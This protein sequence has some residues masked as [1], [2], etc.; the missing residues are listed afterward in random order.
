M[1]MFKSNEVMCNIK[2]K[3]AAEGCSVPGKQTII[4]AE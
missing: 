1:T 3:V 2:F 4:Y